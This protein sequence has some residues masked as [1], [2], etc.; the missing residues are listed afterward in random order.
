MTFRSP[1]L[2]RFVRM[3]SWMPSAKKA[4]SLS[5]LKFSKGRMA[6]DLSSF[7]ADARGKRKKPA[8]NDTA[9]PRPPSKE[10]IPSPAQKRLSGGSRCGLVRCLDSSRGNVKRPRQDQ[11]NR[12]TGEQEDHDEAQCPTWQ[13][14]GGKHRGSKLDD[15]PR[16]D[17][18]SH[19]H[20]INLPPLQLL[21]ECAHG[22]PSEFLAKNKAG[23]FSRVSYSRANPECQ[24]AASPSFPHGQWVIVSG[25]HAGLEKLVDRDESLACSKLS[26]LDRSESGQRVAL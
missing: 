17:G 25:S 12:E 9:M 6:I 3:S 1:I 23:S 10:H 2:A 4:F 20:A 19:R 5:S 21:K 16:N 26:I 14:P 24:S 13:L 18:V 15:A 8:I 22:E 7:R 11:R